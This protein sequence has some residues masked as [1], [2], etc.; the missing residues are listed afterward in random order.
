MEQL[1]TG[2]L[3]LTVVIQTELFLVYPVLRRSLPKACACK[4]VACL[5]SS[6]NKTTC[7]CPMAIVCRLG[8]PTLK[9][10][11]RVPAR[12]GVVACSV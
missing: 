12:T 11:K 2:G 7:L 5:T 9:E 4:L 3:A 6:A 8:S 10:L 1:R